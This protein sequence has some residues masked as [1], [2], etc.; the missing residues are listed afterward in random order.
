M[1]AVECDVAK[2]QMYQ[3][4]YLLA[5]CSA[6]TILAAK[7]K[8]LNQKNVQSNQTKTILSHT[9]NPFAQSAHAAFPPTFHKVRDTISGQFINTK[10]IPKCKVV[11]LGQTDAGKTSFLNLLCN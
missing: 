1:R 8:P 2:R 10:S 11:L 5:R 3:T 4:T 7:K 6:C 9:I